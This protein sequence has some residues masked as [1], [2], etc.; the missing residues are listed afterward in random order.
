MSSLSILNISIH[1]LYRTKGDLNLCFMCPVVTD[2]AQVWI[3]IIIGMS[4]YLFS[5]DNFLIK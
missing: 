5:C 1:K 3:G 4:H 2:L